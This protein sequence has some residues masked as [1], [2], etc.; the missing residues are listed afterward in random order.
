MYVYQGRPFE[1]WV[2]RC[3]NGDRRARQEAMSVLVAALRDRE[4]KTRATA[5]YALYRVATPREALPAL[6]ETMLH[7]PE[8]DV[9]ATTAMVLGYLGADAV[10]VLL[11]ALA[12]PNPMVREFVEGALAR[13]VPGATAVPAL[14]KGLGNE[15]SRRIAAVV[16]GKMGNAAKE[17]VPHLEKLLD[18]DKL[19]I[20]IPAAWALWKIDGQL[21]RT[22]PILIQ[23]VNEGDVLGRIDDMKG[24]AEIGTRATAASAKELPPYSGRKATMPWLPPMAKK[25]SNA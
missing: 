17:A 12:D 22:V 24:L 11:D 1:Y 9:R 21:D 10:P 2:E 18:D 13:M 14:V 15:T 20:R 4:T 3:N 7:D 6:T 23:G 5:T 16:L 25:P 19:A 8:P